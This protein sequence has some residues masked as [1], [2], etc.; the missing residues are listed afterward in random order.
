MSASDVPLRG[1][2]LIDR[3]I[4]LETVKHEALKRFDPDSYEAGVAEQARLVSDESP[5]ASDVSRERVSRLAEL[6][7]RNAAL[8][9][10]L[11][12]ISPHFALA[13]Q[14]YTSQGGADKQSRKSVR[15]EG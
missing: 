15:V 1:D 2:R 12:S 3:L 11:I 9:L 10:N 7:Q 14:G 8:L 13:G 6:T 4:E 5:V